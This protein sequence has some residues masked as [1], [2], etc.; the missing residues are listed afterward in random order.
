MNSNQ[1]E[2]LLQETVG[3]YSVYLIKRIKTIPY[4]KKS[5]VFYHIEIRQDTILELEN[6]TKEYNKLVRSYDD[7]TYYTDALAE[8]DKR[9]SNIKNN[10]S[11][12]NS[13]KRVWVKWEN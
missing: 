9:L 3:K 6:E 13:L 1:R 11:L 8:Y 12:E 4:C 2:I 7:Y 5:Q 10:I